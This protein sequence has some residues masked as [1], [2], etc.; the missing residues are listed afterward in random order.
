MSEELFDKSLVINF[1]CESLCVKFCHVTQQKRS[2]RKIERVGFGTK[3][4]V[5]K[6]KEGNVIKKN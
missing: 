5:F 1:V 4:K 2:T 6:K 3:I